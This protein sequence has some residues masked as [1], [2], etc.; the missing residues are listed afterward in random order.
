VF[1]QWIRIYLQ[2]LSL[3][4]YNIFPHLLAEKKSS[5]LENL[6]KNIV[7]KIVAGCLKHKPGQSSKSL[8]TPIYKTE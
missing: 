5:I 7:Q 8:D 2:S 6:K 3:S 1:P 4:N